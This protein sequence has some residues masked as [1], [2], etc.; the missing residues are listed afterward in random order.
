MFITRLPMTTGV[1]LADA[2]A[3]AVRFVSL[4]SGRLVAPMAGGREQVCFPVVRRRRR[5]R[6]ARVAATPIRRRSWSVA[7]AAF[8]GIELSFARRAEIPELAAQDPVRSHGGF[9][10][11]SGYCQRRRI[12]RTSVYRPPEHTGQR[13]SELAPFEACVYSGTFARI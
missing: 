8:S 13:R 10:R 5:S 1:A 3:E 2:E 4:T 6:S 9:Q 7:P 12:P 11:L